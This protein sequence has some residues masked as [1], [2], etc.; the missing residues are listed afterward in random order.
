MKK[1]G[2][3]ICLSAMFILAGLFALIWGGLILSWSI[4]LA[5][6]LGVVGVLIP[7]VIQK[8]LHASA[9]FIFKDKIVSIAAT[10]IGII[11]AILLPPLV[12]A[13]IGVTAGKTLFFAASDSNTP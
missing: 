9:H 13:L 8:I 4:L 10:V 3:E 7:K 11:I 12:F 1:H 2:V 6:I 5:M